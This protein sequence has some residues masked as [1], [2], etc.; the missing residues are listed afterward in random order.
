MGESKETH[1]M[2]R[3]H[4]KLSGLNLA[5][6]FR[7]WHGA[8]GNQLFTRGHARIDRGSGGSFELFS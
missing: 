2:L 5:W 8:I 3:T 4:P 1:C 6:Q 7:V